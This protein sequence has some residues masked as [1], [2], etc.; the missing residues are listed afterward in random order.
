M[1]SLHS[2]A[3][4]EDIQKLNVLPELI[5][6]HLVK[7]GDLPA[8]SEYVS[9][10][11]KWHTL[12]FKQL[13]GLSERWAKAFIYSGLQKGDRVAMLLPNSIGAVAFDQGAL[14]AGLVP[15]PLH[16][17][18]TPSNCAYILQN[19]EAKVLV[20]LNRARWHSI[21]DAMSAE[22]LTNLKLVIYLEDDNEADPNIRIQNV[23]T[24][25]DQASNSSVQLE[26]PT[27]EDLACLIYTSGTTGKPKGVM[28]THR[29]VMSDIHALL[30]NIC[31]DPTDIWLSFLPLSHMFERTTSY[32]I[33]LGLGNHVY[34]SRGVAHLVEELRTVQPTI[35]MSVPRVYEK[36]YSKIQEQVRSKGPF[37][38]WLFKNVAECGFRR[39]CKNN[40]LAVESGGISALFD[41]LLNFVYDRSIR[42]KVMSSFG[43]RLRIAVSG[44]AALNQNTARMLIGLGL[45][46]YQGYGMTETSP[47]ISVN[48]I[49][50]NHPETVGLILNN[51][52]VRLGDMDELLVRGPQVMKGY[53]KRPEDTD[54]VL[55]SEGWLA[56]GDQVDILPGNYLRI[57]GRIKE[58]I[59]TSTGE[60]IAPVDVE[61]AIECDPLFSQVMV[62]GENRPFVSAVISLNKEEW[63]TL[64]NSLALDASNPDTLQS[65]VVKNAIL[66]RIK[67][68]AKDLPQYGV[69]RATH[70]SLEPWTIENNLLTPTLK[71]KRKNIAQ[72]YEQEINDLYKNFGK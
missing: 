11:R 22:A 43:G 40:Q 66:R 32:Y 37:I 20:T 52:E 35:L 41:P 46:I 60:K 29:N 14:Q 54:K 25:L 38:Q 48:K 23:N 59:V 21:R 71:L 16:I 70:L 68:A 50:A 51:V 67:R 45:E 7:R 2:H 63:K 69:P 4:K 8:V 57:K 10:E 49:G 12:S 17:I 9:K 5:S 28:L 39:F 34:F 62:V 31:P 64:A 72:H 58:I 44:G 27:P 61:Q 3:T 30:D 56:T 33:G 26:P 53:W 19:S 6:H 55:D 65:K 47:I 42:K 13:H 1:S 36:I 18:D 15:V 24:W